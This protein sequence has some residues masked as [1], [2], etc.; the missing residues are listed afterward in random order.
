M[1]LNQFKGA[2]AERFDHFWIRID[3]EVDHGL[4]SSPSSLAPIF[5]RDVDK[6]GVWNGDDGIQGGSYQRGAKIDFNDFAL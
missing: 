3:V 5:D 2:L 1:L 6:V 4:P